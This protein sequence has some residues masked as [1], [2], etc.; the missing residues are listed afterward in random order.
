MNKRV[1]LAVNLPRETRKRI[2]SKLLAL[3]PKK[4]VKPVSEENLH[5]TLSF[6]GYLPESAIK[7][8]VA[9]LEPLSEMP[10]F[11]MRLS[12]IGHFKHRVLWLGLEKGREEL[13]ELNK[14]ICDALGLKNEKFHPHVTLARNKFLGRKEFESLVSLLRGKEFSEE[15]NALSLDVMESMLSPAGP[16]YSALEK[17][18]FKH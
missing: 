2:A 16:A 14:K 3:L 8:L 13:L 15:A 17:I 11:G 9:S 18:K 4:G 10:C 12:G 5:V 6:L 7:E 1:F